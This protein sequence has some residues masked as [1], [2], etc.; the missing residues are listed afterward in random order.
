MTDTQQPTSTRPYLI[1]ALYEWCTDNG[2]TPYVAV[3]VDHTVQVPREFV[4]NGEIVLDI[5]FGATSSLKLDNDFIAFKARFGGIAREIIVPIGR[6]VAIYASENG[7]GMA[8]PPPT[9]A[10][11]GIVDAD[12]DGDQD[13]VLS[14]A[15]SAAVALAKEPQRS[16]LRDASRGTEVDGSKVFHLVSADSAAGSEDSGVDVGSSDADE[17]PR[18]PLPS[19]GAK[20]SLKRVK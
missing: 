13:A 14:A 4:K 17:P 3:Q 15:E 9:G 10:E 11:E 18:P 20:P 7:E 6:V 16:P 1:R 5:G 19:G 2:F 12:E 8:F